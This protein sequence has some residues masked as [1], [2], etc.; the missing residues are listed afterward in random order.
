MVNQAF[1]K[2]Y[3]IHDPETVVGKNIQFKSDDPND[4]Y[5]ILAVLGDFNRTSL[6]QNVE[7]TLYFPWMNPSATIVKLNPA[8]FKTGLAHLDATW[9]KFFPNTPLDYNFLDDRFEAL[10]AQDKRFGRIFGLF[11][12]LAIFIAT[13]GLFGLSAFIAIQRTKEVGVRKVLGASVPGIIAMFYKDFAKLILVAA[14]VGI[15]VVYYVMTAWLQNYAF[16]IEFPWIVTV[17]ALAIVAVFALLVVGFQTRR[18]AVLDPAL[19]LKYE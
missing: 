19:T 15:P 5:E 6:K 16:R 2:R 13:L 3:G 4:K 11:A 7:P 12:G 8:N 1:L 9:S 17:L 18:V 10:Y 14:I